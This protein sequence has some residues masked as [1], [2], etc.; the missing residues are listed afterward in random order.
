M[1]LAFSTA[2]I[3]DR[4]KA[5]TR[6]I[7]GGGAAGKVVLYDGTRPATGAAITTQNLLVTQPFAY[8]SLGNVS[9]ATLTLAMGTAALATKTG[10]ASWARITDSA[11]NFVA[12][13]DVSAAG[14][15]GEI[16]LSA[17]STPTTQVYEGGAVT[18]TAGTLVET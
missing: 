4:L 16:Q 17:N 3:Q 15:S 9:G 13:M 2:V 6:A 14:G 12:D 1:T 11:G 10:T 18:I 8:P 7:D 5:L